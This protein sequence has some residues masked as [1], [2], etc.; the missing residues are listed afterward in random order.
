MNIALTGFYG[1]GCLLI[2]YILYTVGLN[3]FIIDGVMVAV[4][5]GVAYFIL[6]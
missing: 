4:V 5:I 2:L 3:K 1:V 6:T